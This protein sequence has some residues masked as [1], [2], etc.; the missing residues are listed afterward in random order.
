LYHTR[1]DPGHT[2]DLF[3]DQRPVAEALQRR[4]WEWLGMVG[5][6]PA[7]LEPRATL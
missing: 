5:T 2:K 3:A 1:Q 6:P 7:L 4:F